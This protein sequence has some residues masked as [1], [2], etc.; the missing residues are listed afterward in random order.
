MKYH[1]ETVRTLI[2]DNGNRFSVGTEIACD[3]Q[4]QKT[5]ETEHIVGTIKELTDA[6]MIL[7]YVEVNKLNLPYTQNRVI[8]FRQIEPDSCKYVYYD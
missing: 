5:K 7:T 3:V 2:A 4:N 8:F 1:I 6:Y